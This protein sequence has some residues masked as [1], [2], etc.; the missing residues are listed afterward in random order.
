M[1]ELVPLPPTPLRLSN[2]ERHDAALTV[3]ERCGGDPEL[4]GY[5]LSLLGLAGPA[6]TPQ[7]KLASVGHDEYEIAWFTPRVPTGDGE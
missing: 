6:P 1:S 7:W 3:A 5:Y 2:D 4:A